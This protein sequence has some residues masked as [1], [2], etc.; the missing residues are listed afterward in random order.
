MI[1]NA[2]EKKFND[3]SKEFKGNFLQTFETQTL[4]PLIA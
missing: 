1:M 4:I 2:K 3:F